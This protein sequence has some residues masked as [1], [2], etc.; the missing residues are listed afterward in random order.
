MKGYFTTLSA[1][2]LRSVKGGASFAAGPARTPIRRATD[3]M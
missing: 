1:A 2:E 3:A